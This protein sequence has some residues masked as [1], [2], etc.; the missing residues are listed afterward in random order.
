MGL[1]LILNKSWFKGML[2][3]VYLGLVVVVCCVK[4]LISKM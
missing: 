3:P 2:G 1:M 4:V